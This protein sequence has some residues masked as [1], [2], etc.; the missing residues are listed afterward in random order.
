MSPKKTVR[1][2]FLCLCMTG[3]IIALAY[4]HQIIK[5]ASSYCAKIVCSCLFVSGRSLESI[6]AEDLYAIPFARIQVDDSQHLIASD[7]YGLGTSRAIFRPGLVCTLVNE[8]SVEEILDQSAATLV[9]TLYSSLQEVSFIP[10][11]IDSLQLS[12]VIQQAFTETSVDHVKRTRAVNI[13]YKGQL[14]WEQYAPG[15]TA[16]TP[17]LG[18]SMTKSVT[19]AMIGVLVKAGK[20]DIYQ[21][22]PIQEWQTDDRKSI[23][24]DQLLRMSSGLDFG[25]A[26]SRPSDATKMLFLKKSAGTF[27]MQSKIGNPPGTK[28][29]YSSGTSNIL[30][31]IIRRQFKTIADYQAYPHDHLFDKIGMHSAIIEPDASGTYIGSSFM[32]ATAR[33]WARFGQLYLQDGIWAGERILPEGWVSYSAKETPHSDGQYGAH[34]WMDHLDKS[35]PQDAYYA[36]GYEGQYVVI[37]PSKQLVIVRLGCTQD[38][39]FDLNT[40]VKD[41]VAAIQ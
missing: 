9:D 13:L 3:L 6:K 28:W 39:A 8:L 7:I 27:A 26:Y 18:W 38:D 15:I 30:Q 37:I 34:F 31:E 4:G 33:D 17:L 14:V 21:P 19:N 1:Y 11:N 24:I 12:R 41:I 29:Y 2:I 22:A 36:D 5:I 23:T 20:L 35:F 16:S 10:S 40:F 32:Y 25:E